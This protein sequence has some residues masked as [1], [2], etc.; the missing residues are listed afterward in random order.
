MKKCYFKDIKY[1]I[2]Q[3]RCNFC[4]KIIKPGQ[5]VYSII[6]TWGD[7]RTSCKECYDTYE[8]DWSMHKNESDDEIDK[9]SGNFYG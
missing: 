5:G 8:I 6:L 4:D 3:L 2:P 7:G 9:A 1:V